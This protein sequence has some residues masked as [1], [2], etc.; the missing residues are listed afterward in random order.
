M[1]LSLNQHLLQGFGL[2]V[3]NRNI[4]IAKINRVVSDLVFEQQVIATVS[5]VINLYW[6][7]VSFNEDVFALWPRQRRH[8]PL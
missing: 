4:R 7:L 5:A 6:D 1:S 3:N 8:G 2:A